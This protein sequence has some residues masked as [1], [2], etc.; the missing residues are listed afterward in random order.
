MKGG[1]FKLWPIWCHDCQ[2]AFNELGWNYELPLACP[3]C[4][5]TTVM[6]FDEQFDRAPGVI[7]DE[8]HDY[9]ANHGVCN[10]DSTPRKFYSK[11]DLKRALNEKGLVIAGD[12]PGKKY[13]V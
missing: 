2:K 11:T 13:R 12:T 1:T 9:S 5:H 10:E 3:D 8:L 7:G 6:N 4:S